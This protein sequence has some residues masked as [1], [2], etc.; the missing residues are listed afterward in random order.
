MIEAIINIGLRVD[1]TGEVLSIDDVLDACRKCGVIV[2]G[3]PVVVESDS[4]PTLV[5][6]IAAPAQPDLYDLAEELRQDCVSIYDSR[7]WRG[8]LIGPMA[9]AWGPFDPSKFVTSTGRRLSDVL[10]EVA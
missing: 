6:S 1:A 10:G 2:T 3:K 4:E 8:R 9:D 7:N 5:T